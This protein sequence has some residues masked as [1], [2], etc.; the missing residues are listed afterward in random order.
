MKNAL[1]AVVVLLSLNLQLLVIHAEQVKSPAQTG[2]S[3]TPYVLY[4]WTTPEYDW[5]D[6]AQKQRYLTE[7]LYI[8]PN[9]AITGIKVWKDDIYVTVPRWRPGVPSTLNK[10]VMKNGKPILQPFPNWAWQDL[11]NGLK[12]VQSM[13][14]DS[15]GWMW[16]LDV[17][18]LNIFGTP[19]QIINGPA[20]LVIYDLENH[21]TIRKYVFP[22]EVVASNASFL[23]DLVI[24]Q[25]RGLAYISDTDGDGGIVVY[26]FFNNRSRYYTDPSNNK[27]TQF[28]PSALPLTINGL[29][30]T[31]TTPEDGIA[32]TPDTET[33]Y[34][35]PL[36]SQKLYSVPAAII[37]DFNLS[38]AQ[39]ASH[40]KYHGIK[41]YSDGLAFSDNGKLYYGSLARNAMY[42]WD[43]S[44]PLSSAKAL[45]ENK[46]TNQWQDTFAFDN[47]GNLYYTSNRL[48]LWFFNTMQFNADAN[49]RIWVVPINGS[50]Y[51][52]AT[53][54]SYSGECQ[55]D[56]GDGLSNGAIVGIAI[57]GAVFLLLVLI[58][59][60]LIVALVAWYYKK[61]KDDY[62]E[63][64]NRGAYHEQKD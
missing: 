44:T 23:N 1:L 10:L 3:Q 62:M 61:R 64:H 31:L 14:I 24:D 20:S 43:P 60:I 13:E 47:K 9:N 18:R 2:D 42:E 45:V 5:V 56:G 55:G 4:E 34:Y 48:Q 19:D 54:P 59:I 40:V 15:K 36:I 30:Y 52:A 21:C 27:T 46:T 26:D 58:G 53:T 11:V 6:E 57:G 22:E 41:G 7:L 16:I 39:I 33:L 51:L 63:L 49:F 25:K 8:P 37:R 29:N 38:N 32:L 35:C 17:G 50:S 12:Y 28:D